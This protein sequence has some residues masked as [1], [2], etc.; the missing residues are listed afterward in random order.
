MHCLALESEK[1][2]AKPITKLLSGLSPDVEAP[3]TRAQKRKREDTVKPPLLSFKPTPKIGLWNPSLGAA[4]LWER[5]EHRTGPLCGILDAVVTPEVVIE[6]EE[7]EDEE[8]SDE[9]MQEDEDSEAEFVADEDEMDYP[10]SDDD[11]DEDSDEDEEGS[12]EEI[13]SDGESHLGD[14]T[15][16]L[17]RGEDHSEPSDNEDEEAEPVAEGGYLDGLDLDREENPERAAKR[18]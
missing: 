13:I 2:A 4:K 17:S 11:D 7:E 14:T 9:G 12:D 1:S 8:D 3:T 5:M 18:R 6:E 15:M 16:E 10:M